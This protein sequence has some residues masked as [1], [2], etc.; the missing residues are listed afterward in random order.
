MSL[1]P[2]RGS[3]TVVQQHCFSLKCV[4]PCSRIKKKNPHKA[5]RKGNIHGQD[6]L[7]TRKKA[8]AKT[9]ACLLNEK[10]MLIQKPLK[11]PFNAA[12]VQ[13]KSRR[14]DDEDLPYEGNTPMPC[15][16][17]APHRAQ[18]RKH[19]PP[20][21]PHCQNEIKPGISTHASCSYQT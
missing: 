3:F 1:S 7:A 4:F 18:V 2:A 9:C 6:S 20:F 12:E 17:P 15:Q 19:F 5:M 8:K 16:T 14:E 21:P 11:L 10:K 13:H